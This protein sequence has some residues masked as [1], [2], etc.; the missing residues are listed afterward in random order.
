MRDNGVSGNLRSPLYLASNFL[1]KSDIVS[2]L[3]FN[4]IPFFSA[5]REI[6]NKFTDLMK[7]SNGFFWS[8][9]NDWLRDSID[10]ARKNKKVLSDKW[11]QLKSN[12][13]KF[14]GTQPLVQD[15]EVSDWN[16]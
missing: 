15:S 8:E 5:L 6:F 3:K 4:K 12:F 2:L 13:D 11:K 16:Y 14:S 1:C 10:W 9:F 7:S